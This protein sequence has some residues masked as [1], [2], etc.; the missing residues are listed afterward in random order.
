MA[1]L[2]KTLNL[3]IKKVY[4]F[5]DAIAHI[6]ALKRSPSCY[7]APYNKLYAEI[8]SSTYQMGNLTLQPKETIVRFLQQKVYFNPSDLISKF[9]LDRDSV[10]M[11]ILKTQRSFHPGWLQNHPREYLDKLLS[12]CEEKMSL[13][14]SGGIDNKQTFHITEKRQIC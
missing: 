2:F 5:C 7:K 11:W 6:I 14:G 3:P 4:I 12:L 8:N 13:Q 9:D 10:A 1:N